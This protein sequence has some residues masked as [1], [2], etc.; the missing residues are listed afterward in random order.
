MPHHPRNP[1][2]LDKALPKCVPG[3]KPCPKASSCASA[4]VSGDGR[5]WRDYTAGIPV[6]NP[7]TC[8][9]WRD[10]ATHR[11]DPV[12]PGTTTHEAPGWLR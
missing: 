4:L 11:P 3:H 5:P 12:R 10:Q 1:I 9:G 2:V 8:A 7:Q 6:F